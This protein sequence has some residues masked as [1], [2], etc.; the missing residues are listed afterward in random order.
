MDTTLP[1]QVADLIVQYDT[2][3][4]ELRTA[5]GQI[6]TY[7]TYCA[8]N[9][10]A[11]DTPVLQRLADDAA[12]AGRRIARQRNLLLTSPAAATGALM[13]G[14]E[15]VLRFGLATLAYVRNALEWCASS[16]AQSGSVQFF[17]TGTQG[18]PLMNYDRNGTQVGVRRVEQ[19]LLAT[20]GLDPQRY[21]LLVT[22]S[23]MAA[24]SV[25]E[26]F[27]LRDRLT[28]GD[29]VLLAPYTYYEAVE[30]LEALPHITTVRAGGWSVED[31]V[32]EVVRLRPRVLCVDPIANTARQR[33]I[34]LP[35][36]LARLSEVDT[37]PLTVVIDGTMLPAT[38]DPALLEGTDDVEVIYYESCTKYAQLG[39]DASMAG[40]VA[41][42][43]ALH[44]R[45]DV[46]RRNA[47]SVLFRHNAE[48]FPRY[49]REFLQRRM[50]RI[51]A[52]ATL[53]AELL[54]A[55]PRVAAVGR[56]FHPSLPDHPDRAIAE[57]LPYA[58][59]IVTFLY[60]D[61]SRNTYEELDGMAYGLVSTAAGCGV[62]LTKGVSFGYSVPRVWI[63]VI[64]DVEPFFAR[65]SVGDRGHEIED[66]AEAVAR[67]VSGRWQH[68]APLAA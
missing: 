39:M 63:Q 16:Y 19:Q 48:L 37:G 43:I 60:H 26:S 35:G 25:V 46:L 22:S 58:S 68:S 59:G 32:A 5:Q 55:D 7:A 4:C 12:N 24:F 65:I 52:N 53:L 54:D 64:N 21:G 30:Q 67:A 44:E 13:T 40:F 3:L 28:R 33:M 10:L 47:G 51:C 57:T 27:L 45:M 15:V 29:T 50:S 61:T 38:L 11:V 42:P 6:D 9:G 36:L 14:S 49:D 34:D 17:D 23:G 41:H 31:F 56:V 8:K 1:E 20:V 18:S 62:E 2:C 66:L